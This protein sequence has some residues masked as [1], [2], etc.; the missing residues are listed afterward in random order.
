M[1]NSLASTFQFYLSRVG[2]VFSS[3]IQSRAKKVVKN[4]RGR[5]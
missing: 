5:I 4:G 2:C 3:D 1:H